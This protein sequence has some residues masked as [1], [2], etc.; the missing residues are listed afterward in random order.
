[1]KSKNLSKCIIEQN[2]KGV[3]LSSFFVLQDKYMSYIPNTYRKVANSNRS[4]LEAH[5]SYETGNLGQVAGATNQDLLLLATMGPSMIVVYLKSTKI[6]LSL[7]LTVNV[8][9]QYLQIVSLCRKKLTILK[10]KSSFLI[11]HITCIRKG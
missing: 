11:G 5:F 1:M 6:A 7:F 9:I 10:P 2:L 8:L 4:R 3:A